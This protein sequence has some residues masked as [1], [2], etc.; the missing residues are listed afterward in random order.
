MMKMT[1]R[2]KEPKEAWTITK[3]LFVVVK[4]L[5]WGS[6]VDLYLANVCVCVCVC[7]CVF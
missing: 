1:Q 4:E 2:Q 7:V 6:S 5:M 3:C